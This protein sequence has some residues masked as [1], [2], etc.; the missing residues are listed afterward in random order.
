MNDLVSITDTDRKGFFFFSQDPKLLWGPLRL[1][2]K[3]YWG[4]FPGE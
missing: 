2:P 1:L 4:Y 3:V